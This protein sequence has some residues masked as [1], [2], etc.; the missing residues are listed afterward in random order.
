MLS[1]YKMLS[2]TMSGSAVQLQL[3]YML[4]SVVCVTSGD[5]RKRVIKSEGYAELAPLF[6]N[7]GK[8]GITS[9]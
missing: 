1:G 7:L 3:E 8:A 2:R 4:L 5:H 6:A 9:L